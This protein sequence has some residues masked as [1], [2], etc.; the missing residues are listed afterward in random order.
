MSIVREEASGPVVA[1]MP[2]SDNAEAISIANDSDYG[3]SGSIWTRDI[4]RAL[5]V[6]RAFETG[7]ISI[8]ASSCV[9]IEYRS[10]V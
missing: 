1:I 10:A 4:G 3:L 6:A 9:H 8:N 7:T 2:F 5:R